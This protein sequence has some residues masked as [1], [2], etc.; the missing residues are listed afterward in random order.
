MDI[1]FSIEKRHLYAFFIF[2]AL[3]LGVIG[4]NAFSESFSKTAAEAR[5]VGHSSDEL[6]VKIAE[7]EYTLQKAI[8]EGLIAGPSEI[9]HW[10]ASWLDAEGNTIHKGDYDYEKTEC[11]VGE[12]RF[13][14]DGQSCN[15]SSASCS[16][17]P[18]G[19][20][21]C[22]RKTSLSDEYLYCCETA[23]PFAPDETVIGGFQQLDAESIKVAVVFCSGNNC[24]DEGSPN[25]ICAERFG[26]DYYGIDVDCA[27]IN[28]PGGNQQWDRD[29]DNTIDWCSGTDNEDMT[30]TCA[31]TISK[32]LRSEDCDI[33][34]TPNYF[35]DLYYDACDQGPGDFPTAYADCVN[36]KGSLIPFP[37]Y[38]NTYYNGNFWSPPAERRY[39]TSSTNPSGYPATAEMTTDGKYK[40]NSWASAQ[41]LQANHWRCIEG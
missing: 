2:F 27:A 33:T 8:D 12:C 38:H 11:D 15:P 32:L 19:M 3:L 5:L 4:V 40:S 37:F 16:G 17:T 41:F 18:N 24:R 21:Q 34:N 10:E 14:M 36:R 28:V 29:M 7:N 30:V 31:P 26:D 35:K 9:C 13:K 25:Q 6:V 20:N 1:L 39:W 23:N 22:G